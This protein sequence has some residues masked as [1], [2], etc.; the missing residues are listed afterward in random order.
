MLAAIC[1]LFVLI[2]YLSS[3]VQGA[4]M[5]LGDTILLFSSIAMLSAVAWLYT[6]RG[7]RY[8]THGPLLD[9]KYSRSEAVHFR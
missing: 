6:S 4:S 2:C 8:A 7:A 5:E 9:R 3:T 1:V